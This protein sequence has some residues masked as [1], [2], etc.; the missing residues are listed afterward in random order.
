MFYEKELLQ[1]R[2]YITP[3]HHLPHEDPPGVWRI[4]YYLDWGYKYMALL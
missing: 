4:G 3:C 2:L 1:D